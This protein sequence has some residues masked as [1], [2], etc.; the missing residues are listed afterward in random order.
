MVQCKILY[1]AKTARGGAA[2]SLYHLASGLDRRLYEPVVLFYTQE[3]PHIGEKLTKAGIKVLTLEKHR[4]QSPPAV[5]TPVRRR[6][7]G[8]WLEVRLGGWAAQTYAFLKAVYLFVR[9]EVF[10][11]RPIIR[12]IRRNKIDLVHVNTGLRHGKPGIIAAR[13]TQRPCIC[14]VRMFDRLNPFDK[15]FSRFVDR[16]I[17]ISEAVA[18]NYASQGVPAAKGEVI[19]NAVELSEFAVGGDGASVRSEF[20]WTVQER[21]VGVIGRLDWWKGHEYFLEALAQAA[22]QL[23]YLRGLIVGEPENSPMNRAYLQRLKHLV[24]SLELEDKVVFTGFRTDVPRLI[25]ALDVVVLSSSA[26]EPF[27][28]VVIEGMA[29]GK[30]V[31]ATAAGGVPEIIEDG[32]SGILVPPKDAR[33]MGKA[34]LRLLSDREMARRMGLA[35]RQRVEERFSARGYVAAT[36]KAYDALLRIAH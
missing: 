7:I 3:H 23:P 32:V 16:F 20:G 26:P 4:P 8:G 22:E 24:E 5:V 9:R 15:L 2:F 31:I 13:L 18:K 33:A 34:I 1:V 14:H 27:G 12:A 21:L 6:D 25:A 30:P 19:H 29:A 28:R 10:K 36:Q 17:Y 11:V 35:A